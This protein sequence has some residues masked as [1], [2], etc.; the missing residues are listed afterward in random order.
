AAKCEHGKHAGFHALTEADDAATVEAVGDVAGEKTESEGGHE[1]GE[2]D[3]AE[4]Q[5]AARQVIDLPADRHRLHLIGDR[6]RGAHRPERRQGRMAA[7]RNGRA[8]FRWRRCRHAFA[9][10]SK[11]SRTSTVSSRSGLVENKATGASINSSMRR[12]YLMA[13]ALS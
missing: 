2:T 3:Q 13:G 5:R 12:M 6:R 1:L 7:Q 8:L 11:G 4:R 10:P 9:Q